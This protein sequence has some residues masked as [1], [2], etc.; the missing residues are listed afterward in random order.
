MLSKLGRYTRISTLGNY[1]PT[2]MRPVFDSRI[3]QLF[4]LTIT[5]AGCAY[6]AKSLIGRLTTQP[7]QDPSTQPKQ[8]PWPAA[9]PFSK[10]VT[11]AF[12]YD[13]LKNFPFITASE[14]S[15]ESTSI[16]DY[17]INSINNL[18]DKL[19]PFMRGVDQNNNPYFV[20]KFWVN[21]RPN[22]DSH[23][24]AYVFYLHNND[25]SI[26]LLKG[27][28]DEKGK[29]AY[30]FESSII[31]AQTILNSL[32]AHLSYEP[33]P[34]ATLRFLT[35]NQR[36]QWPKINPFSESL[37]TF[38]GG[39]DAMSRFPLLQIPAYENQNNEADPCM[40]A[41][42]A[43]INSLKMAPPYARSIDQQ[44]NCGLLIK[45]KD[46]KKNESNP[47]IAVFLK[48]DE[49]L[50]FSVLNSEIAKQNQI[51]FKYKTIRRLT[52]SEDVIINAFREL[53]IVEET[54]NNSDLGFPIW[55]L[56]IIGKSR[57][58]S[59]PFVSMDTEPSTEDI[60]PDNKF[61]KITW[62]LIERKLELPPTLV[63]LDAWGLPFIRIT[64]TESNTSDQKWLVIYRKSTKNQNWH[65]NYE[66][67]SEHE[68][69]V[70][71]LKKLFDPNNQSG[72]KAV[73]K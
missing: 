4:L 73:L 9:S 3:G 24:K 51:Q 43:Q 45:Y 10:E 39:L 68:P 34:Q 58:D 57:L 17:V 31:N 67:Y 42:V 63:S 37:T 14:Q 72:T 70:Q 16:I 12:P 48:K 15:T 54:I 20:V 26:G 47:K 36:A 59:L 21:E 60:T 66:L 32:S 18:K 25:T 52:G 35:K 41:I 71:K 46:K 40:Q 8:D 7:K 53:A 27:F 19:S 49:H 64:Y 23:L 55:L 62:D 13:T 22:E 69:L 1:L 29:Q 56:N 50:L 2:A 44:G 61:C 65:I 5:L 30:Q 28:S 33:N 38:C 11:D 6:L